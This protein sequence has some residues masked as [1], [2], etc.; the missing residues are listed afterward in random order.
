MLQIPAASLA[1]TGS[2]RHFREWILPVLSGLLLALSFPSH[3]GNPLAFLYHGAWAWT[4]LVPLFAALQGC[5]F[6]EG[7]R[8]GWFTGFTFNLCGLYWVAH[9]QGGGPAVVGGTVLMAAYLGL[10]TAVF[11]ALLSGLLQCWGRR[12]L[13]LAPVLWSAQEYLLSLGEL[14]FPW[15]LLGNTQAVFPSLIQYAAVTGVYGVSFWLALVNVLVYLILAAPMGI[16]RRTALLGGLALGIVGPWVHGRASIPPSSAP[17]PMMRVALVQPNLTREAKW[18]PGGLDRSFATLEDL[19][20]QAASRDP[21]LIVWPETAL[22]CYLRW[23]PGCKGRVER[24]VKDL[25]VPLLTG[26]SDYET[27]GGEPYNS[28][29]FASPGHS[30]LQVYAKM[31]LV[32][33]GERTPFRDSIPL[34][35]DIDWTALTGDLGP[36]EFAKGREH[37]LF[38][39]SEATFAVLICFESVFPGLARQR[40]EAGAQ[41]LVN[42]T[43]DS[44]FGRTA[45]PYQHA[46]L[47]VLRA[48]ENRTSIARCATSGIS[49][50]IDP[51]GRTYQAT[52]IF[53]P[54][55]RVGDVAVGGGLTFYTRHGDLFARAMLLVAFASLAI[56]VAVRVKSAS[57]RTQGTP[58]FR[59]HG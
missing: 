28:A 48:V 6:K 57:V 53:E 45:G 29:F 1:L 33:F 2:N 20:R 12:A 35:R 22:P 58:S 36:A 7:F 47:A 42:I 32:P 38:T 19:S 34:L 30:D 46:Q 44:W 14:G 43:N 15:L 27:A 8:R 56:L 3:P 18:G 31:H 59:N 16:R 13:V 9:T 40:V 11:A 5:G 50:F 49:L 54:A 10:F 37:T 51:F 55:V 52:G 23:R 4:G 24:L 25:G 41:L 26:A 39:H 17:G 21:D